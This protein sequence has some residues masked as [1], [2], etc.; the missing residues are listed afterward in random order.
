MKALCKFECVSMSTPWTT[1]N[2]ST[3]TH[4]HT[5]THTQIDAMGQRVKRIENAVQGIEGNLEL[6]D[7]PVVGAEEVMMV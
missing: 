7:E 6:E 5:H 3:N 2:A 4:T 1:S